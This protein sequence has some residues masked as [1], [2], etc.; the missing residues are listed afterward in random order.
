MKHGYTMAELLVLMG[1]F[2]ILVSLGS[3]NF[4]STF[5][6]NNVGTSLDV[7]L[8]DLRSAQAKAMSGQTISGTPANWGVKFLSDSYVIFAGTYIAGA[9]SNYVVNLPDGVTLT[10]SFPS[11]QAIFLRSSGEIENYNASSDTLTLVSG[12]TTKQLELNTYGVP[13]G[14]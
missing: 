3:V 2:A 4:F 10:T 11:S 8:A 12:T 6:Q 9:A 14:D 7:L 13:T 5:N 1:I